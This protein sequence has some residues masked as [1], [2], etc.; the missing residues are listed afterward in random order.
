MKKVIGLGILLLTLT[1]TT[2]AKERGFDL[3]REI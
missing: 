3:E 1:T 2:M